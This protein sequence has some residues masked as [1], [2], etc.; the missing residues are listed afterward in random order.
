MSPEI[1]DLKIKNYF[2][3]EDE[4]FDICSIC[5]YGRNGHKNVKTFNAFP[6]HLCRFNPDNGLTPY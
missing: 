5:V 2:H 6:C 1:L 3:P 4:Q